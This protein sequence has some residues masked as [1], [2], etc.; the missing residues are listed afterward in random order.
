MN[1]WLLTKKNI[2]GV[3][4]IVSEYK[5]IIKC[6]L[7]YVCLNLEFNFHALT[8]NIFTLSMHHNQSFA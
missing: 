7:V 1:G 2:T 6:K 4:K 8:V 3:W 5:T